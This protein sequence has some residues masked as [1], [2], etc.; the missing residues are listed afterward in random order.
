MHLFISDGVAG[1]GAN[2]VVVQLNNTTT[3]GSINI[4][5]GDV[6]ILT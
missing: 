2:D 1:V 6:T 5:A 3:I 4:T